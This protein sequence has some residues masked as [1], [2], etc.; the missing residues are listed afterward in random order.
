ML[1]PGKSTFGLELRRIRCYENTNAFSME[2]IFHDREGVRIHVT[3]PKASVDKFKQRLIE[4]NVYALIDF[5]VGINV[6]K[7]KTTERLYK[8]IVF[9]QTR[10]FQVFHAEFMQQPYEINTFNDIANMQNIGDAAM[11]DVVGTIVSHYRP[12]TKEINGKLTQLIYLVLEDLDGNTI[13]VTLWETYAEEMIKFLETKPEGPVA[14]I[15]QFCRPNMYRGRTVYLFLNDPELADFNTRY[16]NT[17]KVRSTSISTL[18]TSSKRSLNDEIRDGDFELKSISEIMTDEKGQ[19][20]E[21]IPSGLEHLSNKKALFNIS[22]QPGQAKNYTGSYSVARICIDREIIKKV[23]REEIGIEDEESISINGS[24]IIEDMVGSS[25]KASVQ[26]KSCEVKSKTIQQ[27]LEDGESGQF[28]VYAT[29]NS[30][31]DIFGISYLAC[32]ECLKELDVQDELKFFCEKCQ[33]FD[34]VGKSRKR[35]LIYFQLKLKAFAIKKGFFNITVLHEQ[36][37]N[38]KGPFDVVKVVVDDNTVSKKGTSSKSKKGK[39]IVDENSDQLNIRE[40]LMTPK[41]TNTTNSDA[42]NIMADDHVKR[43]LLDEFS[44][45]TNK[46]IKRVVKKEKH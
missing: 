3:I 41:R 16:L 9:K 38:N 7:Y 33:S 40:A 27:I 26:S 13:S 37:N 45:T 4:G 42:V 31:E 20:Y 10:I 36:V 32:K 1:K 14:V 39:E 34:I 21:G 35:Y 18:T 29:V 17:G 11:F 28:R 2:C 5:V 23:C 12:L 30:I 22:V 15:V 6:M 43:N 46:R 19:N 8:I 24:E 25:S 44:A